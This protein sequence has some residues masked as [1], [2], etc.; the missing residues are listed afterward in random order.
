MPQPGR[1][2]RPHLGRVGGR[3]VHLAASKPGFDGNIYVVLDI[4][5]PQDPVEAGH[6]FLPEQYVAAG[7]VPGRRI[8]LHGPAHISGD[9]AYLPYAPMAPQGW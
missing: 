7:H 6:W 4:A 5:D 1:R 3:Y 8:S 2:R 9:R